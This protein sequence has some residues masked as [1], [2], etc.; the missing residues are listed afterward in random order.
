M[1]LVR[2]HGK[3]AIHFVTNRCFQER[4]FMLPSKTINQIIGYWFARAYELYG[5]G[6][7][8]YALIFL[9]NHFHFLLRDNKGTLSEFMGYFQ[10]NVAKAINEK[11]GRKGDFWAREYDDVLVDDQSDLD[12]LDRY[13][14]ILCNSVKAGL[15]DKA[16]DWFGWISLQAALT[17]ERFS[18]TGVNRTKKHNLTRRKK[19]VDKAEYTETYEFKLALPPVFAHMSVNERAKQIRELI[20]DKEIEFRKDRGYMPALGIETI[21]KQKW[22]DR[23]QNSSFRSRIKIFASDKLR[24]EELLEGYRVFVGIY[25]ET[26]EGFRNALNRG[27][28]P[29]I[30]WPDWS[31]PP[32]TS[33]PVYPDKTKMAKT[34]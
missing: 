32:S 29:A 19:N 10:G 31:F 22:F 6:L 23:P 20:T 25:R 3:N 15:T 33:R 34:G 18:F 4:L 27:K 26:Y 12:F 11:L 2:M 21:K 8:I 1:G 28:R 30:E 14:Y 9:S 7:E 13:A 5:N 24:R 17:G 16:E